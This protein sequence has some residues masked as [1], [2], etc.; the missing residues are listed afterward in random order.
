MLKKTTM[1]LEFP[2]FRDKPKCRNY[3]NM[4]DVYQIINYQR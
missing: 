3:H 1:Q 4:Y 2:L